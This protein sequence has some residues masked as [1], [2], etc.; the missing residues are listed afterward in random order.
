VKK[1]IAFVFLCA[2][3]LLLVPAYEAQAAGND[4]PYAG[5]EATVPGIVRISVT[6]D[7]VNIR[8]A[9]G[10]KGKVHAQVN[11]GDAFL[12]DSV[13]IRDGSDN[14]EWYK[15]LFYVSRIELQDYGYQFLQAHK[16]SVYDFS[17]PY[18]SAGFA[19]TEPLSD[20][21]ERALDH[22]RQGRPAF[23][24]IGDDL[25]K[26]CYTRET[27]SLGTLVILHEEPGYTAGTIELPAG[28]TVFM[29]IDPE[30]RNVH[31]TDMDDK[32][33]FCV[34]DEN[35]KLIGWASSEEIDKITTDAI[36]AY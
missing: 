7:K 21:D 12:V 32:N 33:W 25:S 28:T 16:M 19:K 23:A 20:Y 15:I 22:F 26:Y 10:T 27:Y 13:P 24:H 4:E 2:C 31:H 34:M 9:P 18:I 35:N 8:S 36:S 30:G 11:K 29:G 3:V 6:G 1:I 17:C 14:S 5:D